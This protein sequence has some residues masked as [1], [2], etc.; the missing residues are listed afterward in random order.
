MEK[1]IIGIDPGLNGSGVALMVQSKVVASMYA[2][3]GTALGPAERADVQAQHVSAW[4]G[5][6][7]PTLRTCKLHVFVEQP[8]TYKR[9]AKADVEDLILHA[10][11]LG[12]TLASR[13]QAELS[14]IRPFVWKGTTPGDVFTQRI[15]S[16][17]SEDEKEHVT[18]VGAKTHNV[19]DAIGIALWVSGRLRPFLG[20]V[21]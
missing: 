6:K 19:I 8:H 1:V 20:G 5:S 9:Q 10:G 2:Q 21:V 16:K 15:L 4:L 11:I 13:M 3:S 17:L 18:Q 12:G 14:Y 7:L